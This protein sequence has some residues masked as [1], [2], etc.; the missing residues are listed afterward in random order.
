MYIYVYLYFVHR[1]LHLEVKIFLYFNM[2]KI[3]KLTS[4]GP[5]KFPKITSY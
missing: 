1:G 2:H 5:L 3:F 4:V